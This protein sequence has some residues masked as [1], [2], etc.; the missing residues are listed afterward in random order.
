MR[1]T[2][3]V[4]R[5]AVVILALVVLA[6]TAAPWVAPYP[7]DEQNLAARLAPPTAGHWFGTDHLGRDTLSRLLDGGRFSMLMAALATLLTGLLGTAIGVISARR[8][9]WLAVCDAT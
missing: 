2:S 9:G 1:N 3:T 6:I 7:P 8:R 4:D 5:A